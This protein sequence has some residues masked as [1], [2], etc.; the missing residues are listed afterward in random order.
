MRAREWRDA[1]RSPRSCNDRYFHKKLQQEI[2][3]LVGR[4]DGDLTSSS[5]IATT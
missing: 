4:A 2:D 5:S 1:T 3:K